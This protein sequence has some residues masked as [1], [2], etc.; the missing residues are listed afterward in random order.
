[1]WYLQPLPDLPYCMGA[2]STCKAAIPLI[3]GENGSIV[4]VIKLGIGERENGCPQVGQE[5]IAG[6]NPEL[7]IS[8]GS[9]FPLFLPACRHMPRSL[10]DP[11]KPRNRHQKAKHWRPVPN[12]R[13][14]TMT[15]KEKFAKA[16]LG[17]AYKICFDSGSACGWVIQ[18]PWNEPHDFGGFSQMELNP[19]HP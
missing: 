2:I 15:K 19:N 9:G 5:V 14:T 10:Q 3:R 18:R 13:T 12:L 7:S 1:M 6:L 17:D 8:S 4:M 16:I 11:A